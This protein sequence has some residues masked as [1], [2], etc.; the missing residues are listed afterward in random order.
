MSLISM[1]N[2]ILVGILIFI[3]GVL[4]FFISGASVEEVSII[5][6]GNTKMVNNLLEPIK[7]DLVG[8]SNLI[9]V[10][11]GTE[12]VEIE[13]TGNNN[14]FNLCNSH[15]PMIDEVGSNTFNYLDC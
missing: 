2:Y 12:L 5:G 14:I 4:Y 13:V 7:I 1:K 3:A 11:K 8:S 10:S 15:S 9:T 6:S